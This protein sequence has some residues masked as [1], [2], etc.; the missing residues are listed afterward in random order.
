MSDFSQITQF[1]F[2]YIFFKGIQISKKNFE[3]QVIHLSNYLTK[4]YFSSSPF[5]MLTMY[6]QV[7]SIIAY[8][9]ILKSGKI[10]VI[11]DPG[12]KSLELSEII[13]DTDPS[14]IFI[15]NA[16]DNYFKYEDEIIFR[17]GQKGFIINSD[18]KDVCTISYT[19]AEDGY[20]KGA[21]LTEQNLVAEVRALS[22]SS[23]INKKSVVCAL[24]PFCHLFGFAE[25][26]LVPFHTGANAVI[27]EVN[28]L[29]LNVIMQN[30]KKFKVSHFYTVPSIYYI[31]SKLPG[32]REIMENIKGIY[33]GGIQ[34]SEFIHENFYSKTGRKIREG[35]GLTE[36][37]PAVAIDY[38]ESEPVV[39]SIGKALPGCEIKIID[40][41]G[42]TCKPG[43]L[44]EICITGDMVFKGY[45]HH[46]ETTRSVL[47]NRWLYTGDLGKKDH[48]GFLFFYGL[49]KDMINVAGNNVYPKKLERMMKIHKNVVDVKVFSQPSVLQGQVV[50]ATIKVRDSSKKAQEDFKIWCS[51]NI[52]TSILPK[53]WQFE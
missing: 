21:M 29:R 5:V 8:F 24:I 42:N 9:A 38:T 36:S 1:N 4:N 25:G 16:E 13:E 22:E 50:G 6:N 33:S 35:Y 23:D 7:K 19:N 2:N 3:E 20:S 34:L 41:N 26:I 51:K 30:I 45:I 43:E 49:K 31:L 39:N 32:I 48:N 17:K 37:S 14:A 10:A 40:E 18:L 12:S 27:E 11:V 15:I 53:I 44:G 46:E 52:N 47:K 28:L